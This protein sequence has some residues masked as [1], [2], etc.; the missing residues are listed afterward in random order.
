[1]KDGHSVL[2]SLYVYAP[3]KGAPVFFAVAFAASAVGHIWQVYH[4]KCL[5]PIGLHSL[6]AVLFTAGYALRE[7]GAFNYLYSNQNLIIFILSQVLIYVCP[8]L[9]ELANY[10]VL[11]RVFYYRPYS[12]PLPPGKI[13]CIFGT[14]LALVETLNALGIAFA[15]NTS[16]SQNQQELESRLTV[17]AL[18]IQL[19]VIDIFVVLAA[20]FY[21]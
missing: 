1:M 18:A 21:R 5:K 3:N 9:I 16:S 6:C 14:L 4:Y 15:S 12:A 8:P 7:Y 17:A 19:S 11:G 13:L 20:I 10:H 2:G